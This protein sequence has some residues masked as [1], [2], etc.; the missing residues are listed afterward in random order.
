M[1]T[2]GR[3]ELETSNG[4]FSR[5]EPN[6]SVTDGRNRQI[7]IPNDFYFTTNVSESRAEA[8]TPAAVNV[9]AHG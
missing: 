7:L 3:V 4:A 2:L 9:T 6:S 8:G 1:P 5:L